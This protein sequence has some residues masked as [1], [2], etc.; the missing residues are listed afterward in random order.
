VRTS[1]PASTRP[2]GTPLPRDASDSARTVI[3]S[4]K[5]SWIHAGPPPAGGRTVSEVL[6]SSSSSA[7]P[8]TAPAFVVTVGR[9]AETSRSSAGVR[10]AIT[11]SSP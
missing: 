2:N 9:S 6:R 7:A 10:Y 4:A 11:A 1:S 3:G 5:V 8:S